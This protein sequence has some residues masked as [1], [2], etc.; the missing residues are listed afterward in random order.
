MRVEGAWSFRNPPSPVARKNDN[1]DAAVDSS[2]STNNKTDKTDDKVGEACYITA[3]MQNRRYHGVLVEQEALQA[4]SVCHWREQAVGSELHRRMRAL[5]PSRQERQ[6][7]QQTTT[8]TGD[9]DDGRTMPTA[10]DRRPSTVHPTEGSP[11]AGLDGTHASHPASSDIVVAPDTVVTTEMTAAAAPTPATSGRGVVVDVNPPS[12]NAS[13]KRPR[14]HD[15]DDVTAET[16]DNQATTTTI[17]GSP[18]SVTSRR[19][20]QKFAYDAGGDHR[21]LLATFV[22]VPAAAEDDP[23][24]RVAVRTA[25]DIGGDF[26]GRYYYQYEVRRRRGVFSPFHTVSGSRVIFMGSH[27]FLR[28][29]TTTTTACVYIYSCLAAG[30]RFPTPTPR[31]PRMRCHPSWG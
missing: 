13:R 5:Q 19:S 9:R 20:V 10:D 16:D 31:P 18:V 7:Q 4:A 24:R 26:V 6:P 3:T 8:T 30:C 27:T 21:T 17:D 15:D 11:A 22:D 12:S 14:E 1:D 28:L 29:F 25:C 2:S 23:R